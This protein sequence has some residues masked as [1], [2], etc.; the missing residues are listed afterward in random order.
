MISLWGFSPRSSFGLFR[1][2]HPFANFFAF[3]AGEKGADATHQPS[4]LAAQV[5][6]AFGEVQ[7]GLGICEVLE[8]CVIVKVLGSHQSRELFG[9]D[10]M[11]LRRPHQFDHFPD[12]RRVQDRRA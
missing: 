10:A 3:N 1:P 6:R 9:H 7:D 2:P 5:D 11:D 8:Q 12:L 4:H